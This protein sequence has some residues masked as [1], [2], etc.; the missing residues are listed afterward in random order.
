MT[1]TADGPDPL[2]LARSRLAA[3][4]ESSY[5][6][7]IEPHVAWW[8][9]FWSQSRV[10]VP[11]RDIQRQYD[12]VRYF[13]GAASRQSAPPMPLQGVW[14]ADA[15]S[16]PPWKGDYHNDLNTQMSYMGYQAAG[17]FDEGRAFLDFN[18]KLLPRY[19]R[20]AHEFFGT[21][22]ANVPGVM[23]IAGDPLCGWGQYSLSPTAGAWVAHLFYLHWRYTGDDHYLREIAYP[24]CREVGTCLRALLQKDSRGT[25]RLPLSSS[26]EIYDN[27]LKAWLPPNS[28]YDLFCM[29]MLFLAL[30]EMAGGVGDSME[31]NQWMELAAALGRITW[32]PGACCSST[33]PSRC[34]QATVTCRT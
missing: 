32:T 9:N 5:T 7:A 12:L 8:A 34:R 19:R 31:A 4:I 11:E 27:S 30:S 15:G 14:T 13:Y 16:L 23:S 1:S 28:N 26:P 24:W 33:R 25:L 17:H 29:R 18:A 22:G 10:H 2:A 20:F 21:P 3:A 6:V